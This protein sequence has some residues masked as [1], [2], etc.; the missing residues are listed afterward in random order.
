MKNTRTNTGISV[1]A[2]AFFA[3]PAFALAQSVTSVSGTAMGIS[4]TNSIPVP[5]TS[6]TL[7]SPNGGES[8]TK[9]AMQT[10][11]WQDTVTLPNCPAG[12]S[13]M[14]PAPRFYDLML[15]QQNQSCTSMAPCA[16]KS[17]AQATYV[18]AKNISGTSHSWSVGRVM[19][20]S[21]QT[22]STTVPNGS[23][24]VK[25]CQAGTTVCDSSNSYFAIGSGAAGNSSI[26]NPA[27]APTLLSIS[28]SSG[29]VG[30]TV[31]LAGTNFSVPGT[32]VKFGFGYI[33]SFSSITDTAIRFTIPWILPLCNEQGTYACDSFTSVEAG[34]HAVSVLN[35]NGRSIEKY[36]EVSGSTFGNKTA[37]ITGPGGLVGTP[38]AGNSAS[39]APASA[40]TSV[41]VPRANLVPGAR[42]ES[43]R[44]LQIYLNSQGFA[45]AASG[46]GSPGNEST[47]YGPATRAAVAKLQ[48]AKGIIAN[49]Y[50]GPKTRGAILGN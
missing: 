15:S 1:I 13:C 2:L 12:A 14:S 11:A 41:L 10:I 48:R 43:V 4:G 35:A 46:I 31:V 21:L 5:V 30:T 47:Y 37:V 44:R 20:D 8:W 27:A 19:A 24:S 42:G 7:L 26:S 22:A 34:T 50:F 29:P 16:A 28:P 36:I 3:M 40:S 23:Y 49:G 38:V 9:G 17:S 33:S 39:V 18:I 45:V 6:L 32:K 25:V